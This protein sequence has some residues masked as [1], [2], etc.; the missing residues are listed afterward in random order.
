[1]IATVFW[2]DE[3]A[4]KDLNLSSQ[5]LMFSVLSVAGRGKSRQ[6]SLFD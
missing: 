6:C 4:A 3:A 1:M 2:Y 5:D